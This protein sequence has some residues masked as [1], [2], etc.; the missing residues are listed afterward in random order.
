MKPA[1]SP[2]FHAAA[3]RAS[4]AATSCCG[5]QRARPDGGSLWETI[6][7]GPVHSRRLGTS[8]GLN[9]LPARS[10]LC[11]FDC[12][13]CECGF[14][15]PQAARARWPSPDE[16]AHSLRRALTRLTRLPDWITFAG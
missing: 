12:P 5:S 9:L 1:R 4:N 2:R 16:V 10:K 3:L 7:N 13:Y 11:T 15:T 8:L 14:N 6:I